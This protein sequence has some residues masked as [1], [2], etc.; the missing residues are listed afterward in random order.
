[1]A[2]LFQIGLT[3]I[4]SSQAN[5]A[6]TGHNISNVNTEGYSRQTVDVV[7]AGAERYGA[8]F[9]GQGSIVNGIERAYDQFA[10]SDNI[11]NTSNHAYNSEIYTQANQ[12]DR[13][14]SNESTS[15][16]ASVLDM[17][18][19]VGGVVDNPN[20]LEARTVFLESAANMTTQYNNLYNQLEIQYS[21]INADIENAADAISELADTIAAMNVQIS[22]LTSSG[23]SSSANDLLDQR[24][25]AITE[26]SEY[27]SVSVI[28]A[29]NGMVNVYI[30]SG[31]GLVMGSE[32][33]TVTAINGDPDPSR[34]ELAL[35]INNSQVVIDGRKLGGKVAGL[36]DARENEVERAFNQLGQ[37]VIGLTHSINEQQ[38]QG[39]TLD[40][41]IGAELFND[42][43]SAQSM[44]DRVLSHNDG[45]GTAQFSLRIDDVTELTPDDYSLVIDSYDDVAG[46]ITF[47]VT[48]QTTGDSETVSIADLSSSQRVDIPNTGFSIGIDSLSAT[49]PLQA[50]K[51]FTLRPTRLAAYEMDLQ[52]KDPTLVAAADAEIK[53]ISSDTNTG[54]GEYRISAIN[55]KQDA[56]Y[57]DA[58]NPLTIQVTNNAGGVITY[59]VVDANGTI[60]T[61]PTSGT[62][63]TGLTSTVDPL[64]GEAYFDVGGVEMV[65]ERG[66]PDIGDEI[67]LTYNETG[68]GDNRNMVAIAELQSAKLMNGNKATFQDVY[69][70]MLSE[71]GA[72]TANAEVAMEASSI[73]KQ[74]SFERIQSV[75]GVNMDEEAANLLMY[76]QHYSA[77][78]RVITIAG[79]LFDNILQIR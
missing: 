49:D 73:L 13:V 17:F 52:H 44:S 34:K 22:S 1:M 30:G 78:A 65:M 41:E 71:I 50:G 62:L 38:K 61:D 68:E 46:T 20:M 8:Y 56:L 51:E 53:A 47:T 37:N 79:E 27:V 36:F 43:N 4:Y 58:D 21:S 19:S 28:E 35:N 14:L 75:S 64:T 9:I 40:G 69:S 7:T 42:V 3:G 5:L 72:K 57:M 10:Y 54:T 55:D 48:N 70:G 25:Q 67:T 77:A 45:L 26:L 18:T 2:S 15:A 24:D 16:T 6:T 76:Q 32:S 59:D 66:L 12:L 39:E 60:V 33:P 74:Q 23:A 31:Q 63:L 29:D 11:L